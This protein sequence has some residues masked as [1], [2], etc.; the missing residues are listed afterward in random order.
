[1]FEV[2]DLR[3]EDSSLFG[4]CESRGPKGERVQIYSATFITPDNLRRSW[5]MPGRE[6]RVGIDGVLESDGS[7]SIFSW[8]I[9]SS[10]VAVPIV[11]IGGTRFHTDPVPR[12]SVNPAFQKRYAF[13]RFFVEYLDHGKL[14]NIQGQVEPPF[15]PVVRCQILATGGTFQSAFESIFSIPST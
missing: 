6:A 1:V 4:T 2:S 10:E 12:F 3:E 14:V 7:L 8:F 13:G 5:R 11:V 15:V 9:P